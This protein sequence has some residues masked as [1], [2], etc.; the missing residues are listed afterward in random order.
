[1]RREF[2]IWA[3]SHVNKADERVFVAIEKK[4]GGTYIS[5]TEE[6]L[7]RAIVADTDQ[8]KDSL[9]FERAKRQVGDKPTIIRNDD[10]YLVL[11]MTQQEWIEFFSSKT[12][13]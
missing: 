6:E 10:V 9:W 3:A 2:E 4:G 12:D 1:M 11:E 5:G 7:K 8:T 13:S